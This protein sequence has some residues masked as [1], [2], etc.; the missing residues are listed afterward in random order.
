MK[1]AMDL[2]LAVSGLIVGAP[3]MALI[4]LA[5]KLD[6]P[7]RVIFSQKRLGRNGEIFRIHK[8]RKFPDTWGD[9]GSGVTVAGDARMTRLGRFLE[10][11]K[12][13][14]IPQ[15]WN[16]L[17]GEMSFVGPRPE[18]LHFADLFKGE[19]TRVHDFVPGIFGPNQVAY[20]N[21]SEM[22]PPDRDPEQFY[23]EELFP[24]KA[25]NDIEYFSRSNVFSDFSWIVRGLWCSITEAVNWRRLIRNRGVHIAHDLVMIQIAWLL[26]NLIRFEGLPK[27]SHW[28]VFV[29]GTWLLPLIFL[30]VLFL[31]GTYRQPVRHYSLNGIVRLGI[32]NLTAV[33]IAALI[34]M[35][36]VDR[37]ASMMIGPLTVMF[38]FML[39]T[40]GRLYYRERWR[41]FKQSNGGCRNRLTRILIYGAGRRGAA[42]ASLFQQGFPNVNVSGFLDDNDGRLRGR[43]ILG[44]KVIGSERDLDTV[45]SVHDIEQLWL[46]FQPD[47]HK[48]VRLQRWCED[49]DVKLVVLQ[50]VPPFAALNSGKRLPQARLEPVTIDE[51]VE[52][53]ATR[54]AGS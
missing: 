51:D 22:Y 24:A 13:D 20:R 42:L 47:R 23:R 16:I 38:G 1:R 7:G 3:L 30:P 12:F 52:T 43:D 25:R 19:F 11:S 35:A 33:S 18:S 6:S 46:A 8:F 26:A 17:K 48:H 14:E 34:I 37:S 39:M 44:L 15:L 40:A 49:N 2:F 45:H 9:K 36:F 4:A 28:E 10:R 31:T 50:S 32:A 5:I 29:A 21:E 27:G 53:V 41:R 54:A